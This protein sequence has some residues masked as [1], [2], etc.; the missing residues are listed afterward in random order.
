MPNQFDKPVDSEEVRV[1]I[2]EDEP[3]IRDAFAL[4]LEADGYTVR[5]FADAESALQEVAA[6]DPACVLVDLGLPGMDGAAL[7]RVLRQQLGTSLVIIAVT[8]MTDS[9][10]QDRLEDAGVDFV[11]FKP[12]DG[13][14]LRQFLPVL[15][16]NGQG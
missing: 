8:A 6:F 5:A 14:R 2:V 9:V 4:M 16:P 13:A 1:A 15:G 12:L 3:D 10:H 11:L 7:T